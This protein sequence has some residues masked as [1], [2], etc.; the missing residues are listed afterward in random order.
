MS[1]T[2]LDLQESNPNAP[3][4]KFQGVA[5]TSTRLSD[6]ALSIS[7][8][9]RELQETNRLLR[10]M[11]SQKDTEPALK[12]TALDHD[13]AYSHSPSQSTPNLELVRTKAR[14][15]VEELAQ[16]TFSSSNKEYLEIFRDLTLRLI[17]RPELGKR[18]TRRGALNIRTRDQVPVVV[19]SADSPTRTSSCS[20]ELLWSWRAEI[21]GQT[22][23]LT[24]QELEYLRR[25]WPVQFGLDQLTQRISR[26]SGWILGNSPRH[27]G[28]LCAS[29]L[30]YGPCRNVLPA[31]AILDV[32]QKG[33]SM[34]SMV[35][36]A[37]LES[38]G[39]LWYVSHPQG[40]SATHLAN[41]TQAFHNSDLGRWCLAP[42]PPGARGRSVSPEARRH[43][44]GTRLPP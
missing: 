13:E 16:S 34:A 9:F 7:D 30:F 43:G 39:S 29:P 31:D 27:D 26:G 12:P 5:V 3:E 24:A 19:R 6:D 4:M 37:D 14:Q 22:L 28:A 44:D 42:E 36:A 41:Q 25:Q 38:P 23:P 8:L 35:S 17:S 1:S 18:Q 2:S 33:R 10:A 32:S 11:A 40:A 15:L 20:S 21:T